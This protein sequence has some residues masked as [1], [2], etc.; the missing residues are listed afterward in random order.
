MIDMRW[1]NKYCVGHERIDHEHRV[2]LDLIVNVSH[3]EEQRSTKERIQRLL[4]ELRKYAEFHFYSEEN[5][6]L[7]HGFPEYE[8]HRCEHAVLVAELER[9]AHDYL[10]DEIPLDDLVEFLFRWFALHTTGSDKRLARH[11]SSRP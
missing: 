9:R 3:A 1:D 7:D 5:I 6:M 4:T 2:F 11:L 10:R 8:A